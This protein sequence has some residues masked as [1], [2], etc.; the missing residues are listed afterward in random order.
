M[1]FQEVQTELHLRSLVGEG[2]SSP[3]LRWGPYSGNKMDTLSPGASGT[4][5]LSLASGSRCFRYQHGPIWWFPLPGR[6][7]A[8]PDSRSLLL[9]SLC[10]SLPFPTPFLA[11]LIPAVEFLPAEG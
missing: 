10:V 6:V 1:R 5:T 8:L 2:L 3:R 7:S 11:F 4:Q 9:S